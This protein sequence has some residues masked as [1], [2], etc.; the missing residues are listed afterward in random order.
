MAVQGRVYLNIIVRLSKLQPVHRGSG[1]HWEFPDGLLDPVG[2]AIQRPPRYAARHRHALRPP[3][4]RVLDLA[5]PAVCANGSN[6]SQEINPRFV[7]KG[8]AADSRTA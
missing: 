2:K 4:L 5:T 6:T 1:R 3:G 8:G 7:Q